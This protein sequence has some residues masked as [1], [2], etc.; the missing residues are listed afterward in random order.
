MA[1]SDQSKERKIAAPAELEKV[2]QVVE[3]P[4]EQREEGLENLPAT[5]SWGK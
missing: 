5:T 4:A 3:I 2:C 1:T